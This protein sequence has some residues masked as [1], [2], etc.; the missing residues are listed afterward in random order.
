MFRHLI[1]TRRLSESAHSKPAE[2]CKEYKCS[3][4]DQIFLARDKRERHEVLH[5]SHRLGVKPYGCPICGLRVNRVHQLRAHLATW[6]KDIT[7]VKELTHGLLETAKFQ[8]EAIQAEFNRRKEL[9][10]TKDDYSKGRL[11]TIG[12]WRTEN[13]AKSSSSSDEE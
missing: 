9:N 13:K 3:E 6:H 11:F 8:R 12:K 10:I 4:C 5:L 2:S 7:N 1:L